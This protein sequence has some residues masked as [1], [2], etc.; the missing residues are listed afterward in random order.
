VVSVEDRCSSQKYRE[1]QDRGTKEKSSKV[2]EEKNQQWC[3][4][5]TDCRGVA[6]QPVNGN[7]GFHGTGD[8][9]AMGV[10]NQMGQTV[11]QLASASATM[12]YP[13]YQTYLNPLADSTGC[14]RNRP[15]RADASS[16][17]VRFRDV[18]DSRFW[19]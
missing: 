8:T 12:E 1:N 13:R 19:S 11:G 18:Q 5:Q 9:G 2:G 10:P 15:H 7:G 17:Q 3:S 4:Q 14:G 6:L 16:R